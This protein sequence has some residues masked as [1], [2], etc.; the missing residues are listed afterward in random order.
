MDEVNY[1]AKTA[2]VP[3]M[4]SYNSLE[5]VGLKTQGNLLYGILSCDT[6][7]R[8]SKIIGEYFPNAGTALIN[9]IFPI[10]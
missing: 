7:P 9:I 3:T 2:Y 10:D 5:N 6:P 1:A 8:I 4:L